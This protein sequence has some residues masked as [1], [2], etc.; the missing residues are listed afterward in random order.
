MRASDTMLTLSV[1]QIWSPAQLRRAQVL[2]GRENMFIKFLSN[3]I[4]S[5][6]IICKER[7]TEL[8]AHQLFNSC[9]IMQRKQLRQGGRDWKITRQWFHSWVEL[10]SN[11][12]SL[13]LIRV[14]FKVETRRNAGG[15]SYKRNSG[16]IWE[17]HHH[18]I[19]PF[20]PGLRTWELF[21]ER[22]LK[23]WVE[24]TEECKAL[25]KFPMK[26]G[27]KREYREKSAPKNEDKFSIKQN[28]F[29]IAFVVLGITTSIISLFHGSSFSVTFS[30]SH[31]APFGTCK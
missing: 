29:V 13:S 31:N 17:L 20:P 21:T 26:C 30:S 22:E 15:S 16:K 2:S 11:K 8:R 27:N 14:A 28:T 1:V 12:F 18:K 5:C 4:A 19:V 3:S 25:N 24:T 7:R 9:K 23:R 10:S 6:W